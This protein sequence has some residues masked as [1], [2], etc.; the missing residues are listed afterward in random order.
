M[1]VAINWVIARQ[2]HKPAAMRLGSSS[3][4]PAKLS[5]NPMTHGH[6]SVRK[7]HGRTIHGTT[8]LMIQQLN[9]VER[10]WE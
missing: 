3:S 10:R 7:A 9:I 1:M 6:A 8:K 2:I 4:S 5:E